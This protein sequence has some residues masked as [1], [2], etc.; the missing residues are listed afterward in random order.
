MDTP[1]S[2]FVE[3]P[4]ET[5]YGSADQLQ[6]LAAG[7]YGLN[8]VFVANFLVAIGG[9]VLVE[10]VEDPDAHLISI[11]ALLAFLLIGVS[12][13]SFP[14]NRKIAFGK[15]WSVA[16]AIV[17]SALMGLNSALCFGA[18][19][20]IVMQAIALAEMRKYGVSSGFL[21]GPQKSWIAAKVAQMRS[22]EQGT[23]P[24]R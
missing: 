10:K 4:R 24:P 20:Y 15:G 23:V 11:L 3:Y 17:A 22:R 7:Y 14:F 18:I 1:P 21:K 16:A 12:F 19:G 5:P 8:W 13:A 9:R 6:A 2:Q